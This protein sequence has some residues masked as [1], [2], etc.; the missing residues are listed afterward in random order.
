M[1][2]LLKHYGIVLKFP[3][4]LGNMVG[5]HD[6]IGGFIRG[7]T[8]TP[9]SKLALSPQMLHSPMPSLRRVALT[10]CQVDADTMRLDFQIC[11]PQQHFSL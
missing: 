5:P 10:R 7:I 11:E 3:L 2:F 1:R 8:E 9:V 6:C 4:N